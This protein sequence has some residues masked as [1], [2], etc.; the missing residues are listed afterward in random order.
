MATK[1]N[2]SDKVTLHKSLERGL[3]ILVEDAGSLAG[4]VLGAG[5]GLREA[6]TLPSFL[7]QKL[8]GDISD[9]AGDVDDAFRL[10]RYYPAGKIYSNQITA[11]AADHFWKSFYMAVH[12]V[13]H[14][15]RWGAL[16]AMMLD[17]T[18][19][20]PEHLG[21]LPVFMGVNLLYETGKFL[22]EKYSSR[23]DTEHPI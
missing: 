16:T 1:I 18:D 4:A 19:G 21:Y 5:A 13:T 10:V 7:R 14:V 11:Q 6:V 2:L 3:Y 15:A 23:T 20:K 12:P 22:K 9:F 8:S 17:W